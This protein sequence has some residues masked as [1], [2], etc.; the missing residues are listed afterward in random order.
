MNIV[1][2]SS[3]PRDEILNFISLIDKQRMSL[4]IVIIKWRRYWMQ[5]INRIADILLDFFFLLSDFTVSLA[6][7]QVHRVKHV[8]WLLSVLQMTDEALQT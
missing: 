7:G 8:V 6:Q 1:S 4:I 2:K 3:P 5:Q